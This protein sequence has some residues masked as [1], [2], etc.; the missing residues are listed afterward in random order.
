MALFQMSKFKKTIV[1][2]A[3]AL[4]GSASFPVLAGYAQLR[5][6][7]YSAPPRVGT[8]GTFKAGTAAN[9]NTY[10][11]GTTV[12]TDS[13]LAVGGQNVV[14]PVS[15][16]YAAN[17]ATVASTFSFGNPAVFAAL[18]VGSVVYDYFKGRGLTVIGD[19][20]NH[21]SSQKTCDG[22]CTMFAVQ[23]YEHIRSESQSE[24]GIA[25]ARSRS[26]IYV[27]FTFDGCT[28]TQDYAPCA[29]TFNGNRE[30]FYM[31]RFEK[32]GT[33]G[34]VDRPAT[35]A[36]FDILKN[37]PIPDALPK[38]LPIP[39]PMEQPV[40]NPNPGEIPTTYPT[41]SPDVMPRPFWIPTGDPVKNPNP[42]PANKPDTWTQ[43]GQDVKPAGTPSDPLRVDVTDNPKT[44]TD[45]SPNTT[46][47]TP[48]TQ[49]P[50]PAPQPE[51]VTCG[52]P[53][54]PKCLIDEQNTKADK[55]STFEPASKAL[56]AT[57]A[58]RRAAIDSAS[59]IQAPSWSFTFQLPTAC[60][61]LVTGLRGV[62]LDV[63]QWRG[64]IHDLMS[65]VWGAATV[66]CL[67]G[68]VG[69]TIREA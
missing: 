31:R 51:I 40:I 56:D 9:E 7:G 35:A 62:V 6:P 59:T 53:G 22:P 49:T 19:K 57:E 44:K 47:D 8:P 23:D 18:A 61:P 26:N 50:K 29:L 25:Y 67:I 2:A 48:T 30:P 55:G 43:P 42:D 63:C 28:G 27:T 34:I 13:T 68:M 11:K 14:V 32:Q 64:P 24:A 5:L 3:L 10:T 12:L 52:L 17:A 20:W 39:L 15:M 60:S 46:T 38:M 1:I 58:A 45:P 41:P 66:F 69:R 16:R 36:D 4:L 65:M 54:K 33:I 21:S 37:D